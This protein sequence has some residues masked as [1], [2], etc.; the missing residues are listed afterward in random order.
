MSATHTLSIGTDG[1]RDNAQGM[2]GKSVFQSQ[3]IVIEIPHL[4]HIV[5]ATGDYDIL[6]D[7]KG[8]LTALRGFSWKDVEESY[9]D[10]C[11]LPRKG[12]TRI[13]GPGFRTPQ[14]QLQ[15]LTSCAFSCL[16]A[17]RN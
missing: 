2:S 11:K 6:R 13:L 17:N 7:A 9:R 4:D 3:L 12:L 1:H 5:Q 15:M 10:L 16:V 8:G 14:S